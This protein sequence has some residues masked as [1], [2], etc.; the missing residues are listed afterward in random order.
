MELTLAEITS[1][2]ARLAFIARVLERQRAES[3]RLSVVRRT[4]RVAA[5]TAS[6]A[7]VSAAPVSAAAAPRKA[8][9]QKRALTVADMTA[10][11]REQIETAFHESGHAVG[12]VLLGAG[13]I[14]RWW[15]PAR[16]G[17]RRG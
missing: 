10:A 17:G 11:E 9:K 14:R 1:P 16:A 5:L 8:V 12:A 3:A 13:S 2:T 4:P 6:A 7:P 15:L